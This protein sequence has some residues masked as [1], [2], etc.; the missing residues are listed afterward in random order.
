[1]GKSGGGEGEKFWV[2]EK[3]EPVTFQPQSNNN[4]KI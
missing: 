4:K 1:M 2:S 3:N